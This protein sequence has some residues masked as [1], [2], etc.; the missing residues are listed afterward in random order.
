MRLHDYVAE[1]SCDGVVLEEY[2][3]TVSDDGK[4]VSCWIQSEAG[5]V[6]T[7]SSSIIGRL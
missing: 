7:F 5:K 4:T 6:R 3:T 1:V 2:G